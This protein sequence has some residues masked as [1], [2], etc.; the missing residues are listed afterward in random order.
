MTRLKPAILLGRAKPRLPKL[1]LLA[2]KP[3]SSPE[4]SRA[5]VPESGAAG[6]ATKQVVALG[7]R[8]LVQVPD[9]EAVARATAAEATAGSLRGSLWQEL[10]GLLG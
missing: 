9:S 3:N 5:Q 6:S 1:D 2:L 4:V 10:L 7:Q 8:V